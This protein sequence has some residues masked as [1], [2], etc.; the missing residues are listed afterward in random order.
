M[1][2]IRRKLPFLKS[3]QVTIFSYIYLLLLFHLL[4]F[5]T[6]CTPMYKCFFEGRDQFIKLNS[7]KQTIRY[8]LGP[9]EAYGVFTKY[10]GITSAMVG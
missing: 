5:L 8:G 4:E 2:N 1:R 7:Y 6:L 9:Q 3:P 10:N